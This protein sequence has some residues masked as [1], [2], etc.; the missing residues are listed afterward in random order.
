[1]KFIG[2]IGEQNTVLD[3]TSMKGNCQLFYSKNIINQ[4]KFFFS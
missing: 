2:K 3:T 1:M 4:F